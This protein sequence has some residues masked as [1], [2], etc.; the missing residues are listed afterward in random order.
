MY[1]C[2]NHRNLR[3][4]RRRRHC[5]AVHTVPT[6]TGLSTLCPLRC[7]A[8]VRPCSLSSRRGVP[9]EAI[10]WRFRVKRASARQTKL[11]HAETAM[12]SFTAV[13]MV[14]GDGMTSWLTQLPGPGL[15][16]AFIKRGPYTHTRLYTYTLYVGIPHLT[17]LPTF[18]PLHT[19]ITPRTFLLT[20]KAILRHFLNTRV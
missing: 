16:E 14:T 7:H 1:P 9:G 20:P 15:R 18:S 5:A 3:T 17:S 6:V 12:T 11:G 8:T 13:S 19:P 10:R 2:Y 4:G